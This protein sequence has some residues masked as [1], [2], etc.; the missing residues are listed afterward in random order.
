M[1]NNQNQLMNFVKNKKDDIKV[2]FEFFPPKTEKMNKALWDSIEHLKALNPEFMSVTYGAGGTTRS[3]THEAVVEIQNK[4]GIKSAA[5]LTC[6]D[7]TKSNINKIAEEYWESG[8]KHIVALRGDTKDGEKYNPHPNGY[9]YSSDLVKGLKDIA[10][11]EISVAGYPESHPESKTKQEDIDN[12]KR[13]VDAG[14]DRIITQFF[15]EPEVFLKY[16]DDLIKA[17]INIPVVPGILPITNF[18]KTLE[19][20]E[21]CKTDI[22]EW[23]KDLYNGLDEDIKTR[24]IVSASLC[25][26]QCQILYNNGVKNFH[27][28]TLNRA[29]LVNG[30]C[31]LLGV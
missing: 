9:A 10:N 26:E 15:V 3:R 12:L 22:P 18:N 13:K 25:T 31:R 16:R 8:I 20:A 5:H 4:T 6:V 7:D 24:N 19:F 17:G 2:S 23:L 21:L 30:I 11:F 28:Y 27:F 29:E 1:K 14:A